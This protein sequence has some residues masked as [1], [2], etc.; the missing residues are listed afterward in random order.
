MLAA[1][2]RNPPAAAGGGKVLGMALAP[3][4]ELV[5]QVQWCSTVISA[6]SITTSSYIRWWDARMY[7]LI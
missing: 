6:S 3:T 2:L 5:N 4:R 1:L 7:M